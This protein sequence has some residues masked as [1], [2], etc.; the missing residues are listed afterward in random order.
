[1]KENMLHMVYSQITNVLEKLKKRD[2]TEEHL[3]LL[4]LHAENY[5][6]IDF[7]SLYYFFF[8]IRILLTQNMYPSNLKMI[9]V[10]CLS[11][12]Q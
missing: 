4:N 11:F 12:S 7:A 10:W 9:F 8:L 2:V 5:I 1:M 6:E 3:E